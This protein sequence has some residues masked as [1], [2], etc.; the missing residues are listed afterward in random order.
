[1][2]Q[3]YLATMLPGKE[4]L[5][6][7]PDGGLLC[8]DVVIA[9]S[10]PLEYSAHEL[11]LPPGG[12][13]RVIVQ[14]PPEEV[15]S[16]RFLASVEGAT[17]T[18][19]HPSRFVDPQTYQIYARGH[20]QNARVGPK[21][22]NGNVTALA[23]LFIHDAGLAQKVEAG[24]VRDVSIGYNLDVLKD[25]LGR[26]TQKNL[27]CNHVAVV[28]RG[29]AGSTKI[30][31]AAPA[32]GLVEL[33]GLFLGRDPSTV[34]VPESGA[35]RAFDSG[36]ETMANKWKCSCGNVNH[37]G[38]CVAC[39]ASQEELL[40]VPISASDSANDAGAEFV[41]KAT[42][43]L[44]RDIREVEREGKRNRPLRTAQQL[45]H[46]IFDSPETPTESFLRKIEEEKERQ[47]KRFGY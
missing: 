46:A 25:E 2:P 27:R 29:R 4:H 21:D 22:K 34:T 9:R 33:A 15:T 19:L 37:A 26:W 6:R 17:V 24:Q 31:D 20:A 44:G 30:M 35:T 38:E 41:R 42:S 13:E 1:M 47:E 16:R 36:E 11:D 3:A 10:G 5:A 14:R 7:L 8:K 40:P 18:D 39:G 45:R 32:L 12:D 43:Y 23:D 28:P